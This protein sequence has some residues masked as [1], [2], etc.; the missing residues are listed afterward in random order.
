MEAG[1]DDNQRIMTSESS[2]EE[3]GHNAII[4]RP[5]RFI[6]RR[7]WP[8]AEALGVNELPGLARRKAARGKKPSRKIL[9]RMEQIEKLPAAQQATRLKTVDTFIKA[10]SK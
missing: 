8:S 3:A 7:P 10:A 2:G 5:F 4:S 1:A 6:S 9:R